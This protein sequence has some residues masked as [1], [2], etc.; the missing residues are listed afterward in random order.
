M[1]D[2][3]MACELGCASCHRAMSSLSWQKVGTQA[4]SQ[5]IAHPCPLSLPVS[6]PTPAALSL[7]YQA[8]I[9]SAKPGY[10]MTLCKL[11]ADPLPMPSLSASTLR[12][13]SPTKLLPGGFL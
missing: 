8:P 10:L 4:G 2:K 11:T 6:F 13:P 5:L 9:D 1:L 7:L 12:A 3:L